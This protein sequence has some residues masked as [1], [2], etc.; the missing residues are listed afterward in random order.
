VS[1]ERFDPANIDAMLARLE[2]LKLR[3]RDL[4]D[5]INARMEAG[6]SSFQIMAL[7]REKLRLKDSIS[8]LM[9][10]LTPDIIA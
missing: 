3:H 9:S 10:R 8:W 5:E 2:E 1:E 6:G 4:D 7:K